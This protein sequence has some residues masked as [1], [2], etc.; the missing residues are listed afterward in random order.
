MIFDIKKGVVLFMVIIG[1][2]FS[3]CAS[4]GAAEKEIFFHDIK[5]KEDSSAKD[6]YYMSD[7]VI[8]FMEPL[9]D[10]GILVATQGENGKQFLEVFCRDDYMGEEQDTYYSQVT[11]DE[12]VDELYL[13]NA[14][15]GR[16]EVKDKQ[17]HTTAVLMNDFYPFEV[18]EMEKVGDWLLILY[19]SD[20]PY[21]SG[22]EHAEPQKDG[23]VDYGET[24]LC[25]NRLTG[26]IRQSKLKGIIGLKYEGGE[27]AYLYSHR[28]KDYT[29]DIYE[30]SSDKVL[31]SLECNDVGY[32]FS[33]AVLGK[34]L[35][36]FGI[37]NEGICSMDLETG[38]IQLEIPKIITFLQSDFDVEG[39][40]LI[41]L[42]RK[43][44]EICALNAASGEIS[45][46]GYSAAVN[47]Q[48]CDLVVGMVGPYDLTFPFQTVNELSGFNVG[49]YESP[50][51]ADS[52]FEQ[53]LLLK[54]LA[55]DADIDV[56]FLTVSGAEMDKLRQDGVCYPL[57][58]SETLKK[59]NGR[60]YDFLS[61]YLTT[62]G[63]RIW[64]VPLSA[65]GSCLLAYP[66]NMKKYGV[67]EG[68][69]ADFFS[70]LQMLRRI[71]GTEEQH[72]F[73]W[74]SSYGYDLLTN[75]ASNN[76]PADYGSEA[77]CAYFQEMW[78]G[79]TEYEEYGL[80]NH[81]AMGRADVKKSLYESSVT[82]DPEESVFAILSV[83]EVLA[84]EE[85]RQGTK[86]YPTPRITKNSK[87]DLAVTKVAIINPNGK[88]KEE[89]VKYLETLTGYL[90]ENNV[91]GVV[92][93]DQ[94][95]YQGWLDLQDPCIRAIYDI[96]ANSVV[97]DCGIAAD[98]YINDVKAY[99]H[100]E[101]DLDAAIKSIQRK[102]DAYRNE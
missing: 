27:H 57:D 82:L 23:Y 59:E 97:R 68:D 64:G 58:G 84:R 11:Y 85:L 65:Y 78:D 72:A 92:Y 31:H 7:R 13:F 29:L 1:L 80:E 4:K 102:E 12:N 28:G 93:K 75:Y 25:V 46:G 98:I 44:M 90:A 2:S 37:S 83:S 66:E 8:N 79:W 89:A 6:I 36:Y 99:Q 61:D 48:N 95:A 3:G 54:L 56:Y 55:G 17:L 15:E 18:K 74:G 62:D 73:V 76:K 39:N 52:S 32:L 33:F 21:E 42:N 16:V 67:S 30:P 20:N 5:S 45:K 87:Q 101:I 43:G 35:Y 24:L 96:N 22:M 100:K 53:K 51:V 47:N 91:L 60:F 86:V 70:L 9:S 10:G 88:H 14:S 34:K 40:C 69:F 63:G 26:E 50:V 19:V 71:N 49:T 38:A 94:E 77:F 41:Y 81:P